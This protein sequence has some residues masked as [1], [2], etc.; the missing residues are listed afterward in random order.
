LPCP[1][2]TKTPSLPIMTWSRDTVFIQ[3]CM[4]DSAAQG[5]GAYFLGRRNKLIRLPKV[6]KPRAGDITHRS[7]FLRTRA[8][9]K[10]INRVILKGDTSIGLQLKKMR[11]SLKSEKRATPIPP[12][13][14]ASRIP[15]EAVHKNK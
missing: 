15:C 4:F 9:R 5:Y 8:P 11:W 1:D 6:A 3:Y 10:L 7:S 13:V 14:I 2:C 12:L